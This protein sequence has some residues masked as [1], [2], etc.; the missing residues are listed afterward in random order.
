MQPSDSRVSPRRKRSSRI[1]R[2]A[3]FTTA[4]AT[5]LAAASVGSTA[6]SAR[7]AST[8]PT[9]S[10]R[11]SASTPRADLDHGYAAARTPWFALISSSPRRHSVRPCHCGWIPPCCAR[12]ATVRVRPTGPSRPGA[13]R[14]MGKATSPMCN[15]R[16]SAISGPLNRARRATVTARSFRTP[17]WNARET[18]GSARL[19]RST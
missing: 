7:V 13:R 11:C 5:R 2:S 19:E 8:S 15:V 1:P 4:A 10:T 14:A 12:D 16:S 6:V 3:I 17:A 9:W 18:A